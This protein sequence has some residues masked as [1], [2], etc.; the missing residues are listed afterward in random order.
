MLK[1]RIEA[2]SE[3]GIKTNQRIRLMQN[4][5]KLVFS[6]SLCIFDRRTM[7]PTKEIFIHSKI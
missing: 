7:N 3:G 5:S 1:N 6:F 4:D 2:V